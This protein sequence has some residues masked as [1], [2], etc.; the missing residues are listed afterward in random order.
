MQHTMHRMKEPLS[1]QG[2]S[3][4]PAAL[5]QM[6]PGGTP[7]RLSLPSPAAPADIGRPEL[8]PRLLQLLIDGGIDL[9][10]GSS[11]GGYRILKSLGTGGFGDVWLAEQQG[12]L[13]RE[14]ALKLMRPS[15]ITPEAISR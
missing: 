6:L 3:L 9:T 13:Q 1:N 2:H 11:F 15:I 10:E 8:D 5:T 12:P 14:V 7:R 4:Q